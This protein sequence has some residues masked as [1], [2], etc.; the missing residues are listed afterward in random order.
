M[1]VAS[2]PV[3]RSALALYRELYRQTR[4]LPRDSIGYYRNYLRCGSA[5][6]RCLFVM[7]FGA[8][9]GLRSL[10]E[11]FTQILL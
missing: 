9:P 1:A 3:S 10:R 7:A 11:A 4:A 5:R 8:V 2:G 6:E